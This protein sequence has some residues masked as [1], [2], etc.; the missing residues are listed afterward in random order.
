[1]LFEQKKPHLWH[2]CCPISLV[3][4]NMKFN[5]KLS[6]QFWRIWC[7]PI[8]SDR[9][10]TWM[11]ERRFK[12]G[13]RV[14]WLVLNRAYTVRFSSDFEPNSDSCD[15][16]LSRA[17]FQLCRASFA[18]QCS[19]SVQGETRSDK[20]LPTNRT[21]GWI[22]DMSEILVAPGEGIAQ[23]KQRY[24]PTALNAVLFPSL[25]LRGNR[26]LTI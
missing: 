3:I 22:S 16:F 10:C 23:L 18:V 9:S 1:M 2:S 8:Q 24:E 7:F 15:S 20:S 5:S 12:D 6:E 26:S 17:E 19:C 11:P 14:T 4:S 21:V 13:R 25:R